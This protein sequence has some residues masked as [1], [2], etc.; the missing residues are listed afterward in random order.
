MIKTTAFFFFLL[1]FVACRRSDE[2]IRLERRTRL[3]TAPSGSSLLLRGD[4]VFVVGDDA[5]GI[6]RFHRNDTV[7]EKLPV[8]GLDFALFREP[9]SNKHDFEAGIWMEAPSGPLL[10]AFASGSRNANRDSALLWPPRQP[11][12]ARIL[13]LEDIYRELQYKSGIQHIVWNIEGAALTGDTLHLLNRGTNTVFSLPLAGFLQSLEKGAPLPATRV[14][15][16]ALPG[17]G[18]KPARLSGACTLDA[19]HL[20]FSAS[21]EDTHDWTTDGEVLG[22]FIGIYST[23]KGSVVKTWLLADEKGQPHKDKIES[24]DLLRRNKDGSLQVLAVADNDD[25]AS[26]ILELRVPARKN[27]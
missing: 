12:N 19:D 9:R 5:T 14:Q 11:Q 22:S 20:L 7:P 2:G 16:L 18:G 6:Y 13:S 8:A 24:L 17:I 21:V 10:I 3:S 1:C 27:Q 25:G 26:T 4:T 23:R 15:Q